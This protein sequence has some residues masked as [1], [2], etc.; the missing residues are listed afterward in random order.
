MENLSMYIHDM[1]VMGFTWMH[2]NLEP[3][4]VSLQQALSHLSDAA[5]DAHLPS[6][7]CQFS[8]ISE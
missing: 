6:N 1:L 8:V 4:I 3:L 7:H 2:L 5:P